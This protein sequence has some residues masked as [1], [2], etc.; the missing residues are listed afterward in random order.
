MAFPGVGGGEKY[1][2]GIVRNHPVGQLHAIGKKAVSYPEFITDH[3][4]AGLTSTALG[5]MGPGLRLLRGTG[6]QKEEKE[7]TEVLF[8]GIYLI[9]KAP[10]FGREPFFVFT[11]LIFLFFVLSVKQ[12]IP[13]RYQMT[14]QKTLLT[15]LQ[16]NHAW[17][18]VR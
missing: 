8:H 14:L 1:R 4:P 13:L 12:L 17:E 9:K 11:L 16:K 3:Q 5:D 15:L 18:C 2:Y 6:Q 7:K 10:C